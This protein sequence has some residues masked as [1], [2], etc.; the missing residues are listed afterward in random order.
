M[1]LIHLILQ[2]GCRFPTPQ[3]RSFLVNFLT[4]LVTPVGSEKAYDGVADMSGLVVDEL[5]KSL[6]DEGN[7]NVYAANVD[8]EVDGILEEI[9]FV[10]DP[11]TTWWEV[12][13]A[14][15]MAGFFTQAMLSATPCDAGFSRCGGH[16]PFTS[17]Y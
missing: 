5:Y 6:A 12:T 10:H 15:F 9:G 4:L 16:L 11:Q 1:R 2:L 8:E 13:D 3:E 17:D 7:P 14:L